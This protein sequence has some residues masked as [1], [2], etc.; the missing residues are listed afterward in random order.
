MTAGSTFT[1]PSC[2]SRVTAGEDELQCED[3]SETVPV[4]D[5]I[6]QFPVSGADSSSSDVFDLLSPI[7]ESPLWFRPLY[8]FTGGP[9][10]PTSDRQEIA[11]R[12]DPAGCDVLDVACGT[13]RF[14]R[15]VADDASF[16]CGVDLAEGMLQRAKRH[17]ERS[18]AENTQFARM[19]ATTLQFERGQFDRVACCW[20]LHLFGDKLAAVEEIHRVLS[21]GGILAGATLVDEY[22]LAQPGMQEIAKQTIGADVFE[23]GEFAEL[24]TAGGFESIDLDRRGGALFFSATA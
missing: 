12:L 9:A 18:G 17:T 14:S 21:P 24:L 15:Y 1:C 5:E 11:T 23:T 13:G 20:A 3:C 2:A 16:L 8:R 6:P 19:D 10:A 4:V 22:V 7:Y